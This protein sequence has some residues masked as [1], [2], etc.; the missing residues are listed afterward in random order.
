MTVN[1]AFPWVEAI[2]LANALR[3]AIVPNFAS[4]TGKNP[5]PNLIVPTNQSDIPASIISNGTIS[6]FYGHPCQGTDQGATSNA[7]PGYNDLTTYQN[8][9]SA[10]TSN[11]EVF[12]PAGLTCALTSSNNWAVN[13]KNK[14]IRVTNISN[15]LSIIVRVT[16][17]AP[18]NMGVEL[19]YRAWVE[20]GK[21][22]G[23][24]TLKVELMAT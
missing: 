22:L 7:C 8:I 11:G 5:L 6:A 2:Q 3:K 16:D 24:G 1:G 15:G 18:A 19:S 14:F 9:S 23:A 20:I 17:T 12:H 10:S 21:P 4:A 13:Y